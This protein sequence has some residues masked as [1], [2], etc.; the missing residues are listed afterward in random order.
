MAALAGEWRFRPL[1]DAGC[2]VELTLT[3]EL[4][5]RVMN[6]AFGQLWKMTADRMVD[7]F[8]ARA[9]SVYG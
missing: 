9:E 5:S 8:C 4:D 6:V 3:F 1:A 7:A 2:K